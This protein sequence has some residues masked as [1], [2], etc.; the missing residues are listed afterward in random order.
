MVAAE[1]QA[2]VDRAVR[3]PPD[4]GATAYVQAVGIG[5]RTRQG[6]RALR[7]SAPNAA[8]VWYGSNAVLMQRP[9]T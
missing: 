5:S 4:R 9:L 1:V 6:N 2:E 3:R 7:C 8:S